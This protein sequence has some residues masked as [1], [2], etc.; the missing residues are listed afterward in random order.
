MK[1]S[2]ARWVLVTEPLPVPAAFGPFRSVRTP[3]RTVRASACAGRV[4]NAETATAAPPSAA[5]RVIAV[6]MPHPSCVGGSLGQ[7]AARA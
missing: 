3:I 1:S 4:P 7:E 6:A 2:A 5:R